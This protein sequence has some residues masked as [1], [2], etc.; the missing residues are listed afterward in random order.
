MTGKLKKEWVLTAQ[1]YNSQ[2]WFPNRCEPPHYRASCKWLLKCTSILGD[3]IP[4]CRNLQV[5]VETHSQND[6]S[7]NFDAIPKRLFNF[8]P[9][10][11][12][13]HPNSMPGPLS[14]LI[15]CPLYATKTHKIR[16]KIKRESK[17]VPTCPCVLTDWGIWGGDY[18][19]KKLSFAGKINFNCNLQ[20]GVET[21]SHN[22]DAIR[23]DFST[24]FP[25][26]RPFHPTSM[27][28][29]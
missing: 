9:K 17:Y 1:R 6:F 22:F 25:K 21:Y 26:A 8:Y 29:V 20:V 23:N 3:R 24:F 10:T 11:R 13:F 27:R 28:A 5:G 4:G 15:A 2:P 12:P 19:K 14:Q 7:H 16:S 18:D